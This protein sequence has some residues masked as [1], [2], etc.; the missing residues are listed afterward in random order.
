MTNAEHLALKAATRTLRKKHVKAL[1]SKR[2]IPGVVYGSKTQAQSIEMPL[3][4]LTTVYSKGG[5]STLIDLS[6]DNQN[7]IKVV[8]QAIDRNFVSHD[9]EHVDFYAV[10]MA[11]TI[12]AEVILHFTGE[13]P[14]VKGLG[15]TLVKN[16]DHITI[17]CLPQDL[18]SEITIDISGLK[19]F[20]D[21]IHINDLNLPNT[22]EILDAVDETIALVAPPRSE[23]EL[24]ALNEVAS[25]DISKVEGVVKEEKESKDEAAPET[26]ATSK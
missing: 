24:A 5:E 12:H 25:E 4:D 16:R 22:V 17:K 23:E 10:D 20:E 13:S 26:K 3:Q 7:P 14:A 11:K 18:V 19:T 8:I 1:R 2:I 15:G 21:A 9:I 6:I